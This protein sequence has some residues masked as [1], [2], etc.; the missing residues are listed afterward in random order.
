M[1]GSGAVTCSY[2]LA[3]TG[4]DGADLTTDQEVAGSNPAERTLKAQVSGTTRWSTEAPTEA[5][6]YTRP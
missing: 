6:P 2:A 4:L 3:G 1:D 5:Q